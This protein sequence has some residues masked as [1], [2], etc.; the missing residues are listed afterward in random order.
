MAGRIGPLDARLC[1]VIL[2]E[3]RW[4]DPSLFGGRVRI[5]HPG[6]SVP[7]ARGEIT[8][9]RWRSSGA[10]ASFYVVKVASQP[11]VLSRLDRRRERVA[12]RDLHRERVGEPL[13]TWLGE[14]L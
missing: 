6:G 11:A 13:V 3:E 12:E 8:A 5:S 4:R 14:R 10:P 1:P 9:L 2:R 7:H